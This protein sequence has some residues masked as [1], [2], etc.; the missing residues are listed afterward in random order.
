MGLYY[1]TRHHTPAMDEITGRYGQLIEIEA[2]NPDDAVDKYMDWQR[3]E[4]EATI[5]YNWYDLAYGK[6][7]VV[8][9]TEGRVTIKRDDV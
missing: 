8:I 7:F 4:L 2:D 1:V 9:P 6:Y 3:E 5:T